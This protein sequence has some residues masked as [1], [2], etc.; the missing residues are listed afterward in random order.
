[1]T[2]ED[3][4]RTRQKREENEVRVSTTS[5]VSPKRERQAQG[6][7]KRRKV[8]EQQDEVSATKQEINAAGQSPFCSDVDDA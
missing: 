8:R 5:Q 7:T 3:I 1:M 4:L 6:S 2:Y